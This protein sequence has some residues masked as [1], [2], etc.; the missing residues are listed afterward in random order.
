V[1]WKEEEMITVGLVMGGP[2]QSGTPFDICASIV[3]CAIGVIRGPLEMGVV[4]FVNTIFDVPGSINNPDF[5]GYKYGYY[6]KKEIG[7]VVAV[8]VPEEIVKG[9]D[10]L[11]FFEN[12]L[13]TANQMAYDFLGKRGHEFPLTDAN[14]LVETVISRIGAGYIPDGLKLPKRKLT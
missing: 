9:N 5:E 11:P 7:V 12:A 6:S 14:N 10:P 13:L 1:G 4:P 2:E 3:L 8:S